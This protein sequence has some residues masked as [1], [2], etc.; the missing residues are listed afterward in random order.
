MTY[1]EAPVEQSRRIHETRRYTK[2]GMKFSRNSICQAWITPTYLCFQSGCLPSTLGRGG[3]YGYATWRLHPGRL[4]VTAVSAG[5]TSAPESL[6]P[7]AD[8]IRPLRPK[9]YPRWGVRLT[10]IVAVLLL[11]LLVRSLAANK[12]IQWRYVAEYMTDRAI[13]DGV[14][15]TLELTV[16]SQLI[17]IVLGFIAA[18]CGYSR[19]PVLHTISQCYIWLFRGTPLLVQLLV[20][21]NIALLFP[22]MSIGIPFTAIHAGVATNTVITAYLAAVLGLGLNEGAYMA[23][24]IRGGIL[25]IPKG[26]LEAA[27]SIGMSRQRAFRK[28]VLPQTIRVIIPPTGNQFIGLLKASS[29]VSA[30][31]GGDL[32]TRAQL[33]YAANFRVVPLLVVACVWYLILVTIASIGQYYL[34]RAVDHDRDHSPGTLP[35]WRRVATR[36]VSFRKDASHV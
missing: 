23:E 9:S 10:A 25:S 26:Q 31:G 3:G 36:V 8:Q 1:F 32:L 16:L 30:I 19:N 17:A 6:D 2:T 21:F 12:N 5:P 22:T 27:M 7:P 13:L 14:V 18:Y 33:I 15:T 20:W 28:I 11:A 24:I 35:P 4:T 34:E 29:L